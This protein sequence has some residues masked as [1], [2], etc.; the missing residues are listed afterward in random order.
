MINYNYDNASLIALMNE[1]VKRESSIARSNGISLSA[2]ENL[3]LGF[4]A[5]Q[6]V[7]NEEHFLHYAGWFYPF[8]KEFLKTYYWDVVRQEVLIDCNHRCQIKGC[9]RR[10]NQVHHMSY[11]ICGLEHENLEHLAG[12]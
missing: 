10:A 9:N 3:A 5:L 12:L 2:L 1:A 11:S 4:D 6:D 8:R 7:Y